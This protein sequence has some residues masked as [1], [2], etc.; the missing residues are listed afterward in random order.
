MF[1]LC[2]ECANIQNVLHF[3]CI[4]LNVYSVCARMC[5]YTKCFTFSLHRFKCLFCVPNVQIYKMFY[6]FVALSFAL[7]LTWLE[8][9]EPRKVLGYPVLEMD[10]DKPSVLGPLSKCQGENPCLDP[11]KE[12]VRVGEGDNYFIGDIRIPEGDWCLP[13][14]RPAN[15]GTLTGKQVW[16]AD[17]WRCI[18]LY[19][20]VAGG[21][22]CSQ[23][24]ACDCEGNVDCKNKLV[25][26]DGSTEYTGVG[27]PYNQRAKCLC[28][29]DMQ[30]GQMLA[31]DPLRCHKD[32]CTTDGRA[33]GIFLDGKCQ[34]DK[35]FWIES[36][37]DHKCH[38]PDTNCNWDYEAKECRC[39]E[40]QFPVHCQSN[41]YKRPDYITARCEGNAG[42]CV[43]KNP[44]DGYCQNNSITQVEAV[45]GK[46]GL[47]K[48]SCLCM[49]SGNKCYRGAQCNEFCYNSYKNIGYGS[50]D[51]CCFGGG[52]TCVRWSASTDQCLMWRYDCNARSECPKN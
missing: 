47:Y 22:D 37:V 51:Q 48:C 2:A 16:T 31:A 20:D 32:P 13:R 43:C 25:L 11:L 44:C 30:D 29:G 6:I 35:M 19:P 50:L 18:C 34:C 36:N 24:T 39:G 1:I 8:S 49:S 15:C 26:A 7:L 28:K 12:C 14:G 40:G 5:K 41:L 4:D 17:G 27:N 23:K 52:P 45:P 42:G 33:P 10:K 21:I 9:M 46:P 3:R 38:K